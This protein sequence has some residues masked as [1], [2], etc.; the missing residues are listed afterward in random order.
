MEMV[1]QCGEGR[2]G[3]I[4]GWFL[5]KK[6]ICMALLCI[7][8]AVYQPRLCLSRN[9]GSISKEAHA[10]WSSREAL[11]QNRLQKISTRA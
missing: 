8:K 5:F 1:V 4:Y 10:N 7:L 3:H 9:V 11:Q 6:P 2:E